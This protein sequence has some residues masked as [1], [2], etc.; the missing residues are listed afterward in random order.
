MSNHLLMTTSLNIEDKM[1]NLYLYKHTHANGPTNKKTIKQIK[2]RKVL[3]YV[4]P[5][6]TLS[7]KFPK[8]T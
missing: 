6:K 3:I 4:K 1:E 5:Q 7:Q 2:L 8:I